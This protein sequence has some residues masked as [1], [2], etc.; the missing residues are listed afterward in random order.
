M[1]LQRSGDPRHI[2]CGDGNDILGVFRRGPAKTAQSGGGIVALNGTGRVVGTLQLGNQGLLGGGQLVFGD[3]AG[4]AGL[5]LGQ[6]LLTDHRFLMEID[7]GGN[8]D[9]ALAAVVA[10]ADVIA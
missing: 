10:G 8:G 3:I 2:R 7:T 5:Q 6:N 4:L 1:Q 9:D